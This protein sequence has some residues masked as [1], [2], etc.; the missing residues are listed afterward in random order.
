MEKYKDPAFLFYPESFLVGVMDMTDAE[1]GQYIK[2]LCRQHQKGHIPASVMERQEEAVKEKFKKD[3]DGRF[4]NARLEL[5]ISKRKKRISANRENGKK[6]GR[7]K[8]EDMNGSISEWVQE[9]VPDGLVDAFTE[10]AEMR[11]EIGSPITTRKTIER[12]Y[13]KLKTMS[14]HEAKQKAILLQSVDNKWKNLYP[15]PEGTKVEI[16][17]VPT[18]EDQNEEY[19]PMPK[20]FEDGVAK[21][22]GFRKEQT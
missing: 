8:K 7:P 5:E 9:I 19:V 6:G 10:F 20:S 15:L 1:V 16:K 22:L 14:R 4:Y 18:R 12:Q 2:L 11:A 21:A 13:E 17:E 3:A